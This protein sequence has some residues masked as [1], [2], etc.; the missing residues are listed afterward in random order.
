VAGGIPS[1]EHILGDPSL[2]SERESSR[3]S[4]NWLVRLHASEWRRAASCL[5]L[6][7]LETTAGRMTRER[8]SGRS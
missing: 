7:H 4:E 3:E 2:L 8:R 6:R 1:G 5:G